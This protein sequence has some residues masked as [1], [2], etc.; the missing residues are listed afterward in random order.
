MVL[1]DTTRRRELL[2]HLLIGTASKDTNTRLVLSNQSWQHTVLSLN[3]DKI[4]AQVLRSLNRLSS[5]TLH[6]ADLAACQGFDVVEGCLVV[7]APLSFRADFAEEINRL[8]G[9]LAIGSLFIQHDGI[10]TIKDAGGNVARLLSRGLRIGLNHAVKHLRGDDDGLR[11]QVRLLNHPLLS[12][13][14]LVLRKLKGERLTYD[15]D[16]VRDFQNLVKV[17][18]TFEVLDL[19][20]DLQAIATIKLSQFISDSLNI[21]GGANKRDGH[22]SDRL[23]VL[24]SPLGQINFIFVCERGKFKICTG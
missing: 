18:Q 19:R 11:S 23:C 15:H 17:F 8:N 6:R 3:D 20:D 7:D 24:T 5:K 14:H 2:E 21:F 1:K 13:E 12:N 22:H 10:N 16:T 4:N 9:L